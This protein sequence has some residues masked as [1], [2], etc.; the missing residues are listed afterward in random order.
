MYASVMVVLLNTNS[1]KSAHRVIPSEARDL[2]SRPSGSLAALG[3]TRSLLQ[4]PSDQLFHDLIG[5]AVDLLDPR[6]GV[7][8]GGRI[9]PHVAV[10]AEEL[11][12]L[13][14]QLALQVGGVVLGHRR[15]GD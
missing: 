11:Q 15:G 13:V 12:A 14:D 6:I 3:M 10:A 2:C 5:A 1:P 7:E 9:F 8:A 4:R